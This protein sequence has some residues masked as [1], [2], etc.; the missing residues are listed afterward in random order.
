MPCVKIVSTNE[1]IMA[2]FTYF[3]CAES[4][5]PKPNGSLLM[6]VPVSTIAAV[7]KEVKQVLDTSGT[8]AGKSPTPTSKRGKYNHFTPKE[9][10]QIGKR[11]AE[12]GVTWG[13]F[14]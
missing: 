6:V 13:N 8:A 3:Q 14:S 12:H 1:L 5:L 2:L 7:N 9:K 10:A 4:I 11:A